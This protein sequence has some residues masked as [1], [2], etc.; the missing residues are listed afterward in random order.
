MA[1]GT[2]FTVVSFILSPG[3]GGGGI[4]CDREDMC[5]CVQRVV[6]PGGVRG[7]SRECVQGVSRGEGVSHFS[8]GVSFFT[9]GGFPFFTRESPIFHRRGVS[10]FSENGRPPNTGIWLM[11]GRSASYWNV[12]LLMLIT[13][14]I[15]FETIN[16][17]Q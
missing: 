14:L 10:H 9:G 12:F 6:C 2:I 4:W 7:V 13:S 5:M 15:T 11:C 1:E 17:Y 8:Q 16:R 3:G